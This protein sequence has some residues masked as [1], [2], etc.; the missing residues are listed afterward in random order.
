MFSVWFWEVDMILGDSGLELGAMT[1]VGSG[2]GQPPR[3][4]GW[5]KK[6]GR[7]NKE[8]RWWCLMG[9]AWWVMGQVGSASQPA[10]EAEQPKQA[11]NWRL[12]KRKK[13]SRRWSG[14]GAKEQET[15]DRAISSQA[16]K[17]SQGELESTYSPSKRRCW[18]AW[19]MKESANWQQ[20]G[21]EV[22]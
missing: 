3:A 18:V 7:E 11:S 4:E 13:M 5:Q 10:Q 20:Q 21:G 6:R 19:E 1:D 17:S 8:E 14:T 9:D 16:A 2:R 12:L 22:E 15:R